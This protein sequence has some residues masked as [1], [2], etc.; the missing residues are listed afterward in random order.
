MQFEP[1]LNHL[2]WTTLG[3]SGL[4]QQTNNLNQTGAVHFQFPVQMVQSVLTIK[5]KC[6]LF[7]NHVSVLNNLTNIPLDS[8]IKD[9]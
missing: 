8:G 9:F 6:P 2:L 5:G 7:Q 4:S 3:F 1:C